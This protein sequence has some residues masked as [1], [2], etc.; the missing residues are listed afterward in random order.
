MEIDLI[1]FPIIFF[2]SLITTGAITPMMRN[3]ALSLKIVDLPDQAHK[4]HRQPIPYLGGLAI[5]FGVVITVIGGSF[6][7]GL[8]ADA[9][10]IL[11]SILVPSILIGIIGLIDDLKNLSPT[12]RLIAQSS[13]ALITWF[14]IISGETLGT[15][16]ENFYINFL[17]TFLWIVGITN[18]INF[19]DNHDG[20]ASGTIAISSLTLSILSFASGQLYIAA[21][22]LVLSGACF[23]FLFWNKS[24]ARIYMGDAG[25]LFL[26][27]VI[28]TLV[29]RFDP[30]ALNTWEGLALPILLLALPILDTSIV[31]ISRIVRGTSPLQGGQDHL[32]HRLKRQGLTGKKTTLIL[33][34]DASFFCLLAIS[35]FFS[36]GSTQIFAL[37]LGFI[38]WIWQFVWFFKLPHVD[39]SERRNLNNNSRMA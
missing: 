10:K 39:P 24:P 8:N 30:T 13:A 38:I 28:S 36:S 37:L 3:L 20:G 26:G 34:A 22:S 11:I 33:W 16:T 31:V 12:L 6:L 17:I 2:S 32:S 25:S 18:A 15:P 4:I 9:L 19:F 14:L 5:I 27:M 21:L 23:G 35:A 7:M 1:Q 29:I